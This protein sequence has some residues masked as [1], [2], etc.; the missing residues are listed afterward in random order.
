MSERLLVLAP[1]PDDEVLGCTALMSQTLADGGVVHVVVVTDGALGGPVQA[2]AQELQAGLA[3][4]G[5]PAAECWAYPDDALPQ[6]G[7]VLDRYRALVR[8]WRPTHLA[9][10]APGEAH[11]D[12]RRLTRGVIEALT[13]HWS[14][15]LVFYETTTPQVQVNQLVPLDLDRKLQALA[16]HASQMAQFDYQGYA[17]GLALLR[18]ASVGLPAAEGHLCFEWDGSAQNFFEHRPLVSVVLR[19]HDDSLLS[20]AL[21]SLRLQTYDHLEALVI[22]HGDAALPALPPDLAGQVVRGPGPHG[23]NLN[24]GLDLAR[25][26]FVAFLDHDDVWKPDHLAIL[27]AELNADTGLDLAYGDY[28]RVVCRH[29]A[30]GVQVMQRELV[31]TRD[32]RPARLMVGNHIPLHSFVCRTRLARR[33]RFD[34]ALGAYEDWDFLLRLELDDARLRRVPAVV[35]EYRIYPQPG[36]LHDLPTQHARKGYLRWRHEVVSRLLPRLTPDRLEVL[37]ALTEDL[38]SERDVLLQRVRDADA[39]RRQAEQTL[40]QQTRT[41]TE[42]HHW[43]DRLAPDTL[44]HSPLSRLVGRA[45][46]DGPVIAVLMPV[47]DP[48]PAFLIEVVESVRQQTYPNWQLCL[49]DDACRRPEVRA[50]LQG[51]GRLDPRIR[52]IRN[53]ERGGIVQATT[54]ALQLTQA[55]WLAF[56]DHDDR[57]DPDALLEIAAAVRADPALQALYTDSRMI[58]R[59]GVV[60]HTYAKPP[61]C[62]ETLLHLNYINH[63]SVVKREVF[64]AVGGLRPGLDGSQDWDLWLRLAQRPDL[65]VGHVAQP[66][67]DWRAAETSVAYSMATKPYI[68][69]AACR[70]TREHLQARGLQ[71]VDSRVAEGAGGLRHHWAANLLPMTAII[72]THHNPEDL[73]ALVA[74]L[75]ASTYPGLRVHVVANRVSPDDAATQTLLAEVAAWSH[76]QV[77]VD[78]R[79]FNWSALNNAEARHCTTPWLL[80]LNDDVAWDAPDTLERL[81]RYLTLDLQIGA[82]GMALHY[83]KDQGGG[84]QHDGVAT[85][86]VWVARNIQDE[87]D[88]KGLG[89]P[90]NVSAVTGACLLT[91]RAVFERCGGFDERLAV[92]YNDVDYGLHLRRLGYRV[93]QASDVQGRHHESKTRGTPD[94]PAKLAQLA[95]EGQ[96]MRDKWGDLLRETHRLDYQSRFVGSRIVHMPQEG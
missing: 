96:W 92:S 15:T 36:E 70:A 56:V 29:D 38:E 85:D 23:A 28:E 47:C 39:A 3:V 61:W 17:R 57:L 72:L 43:A 31:Q 37:R 30:Q 66:L 60:L 6:S 80:F 68:V 62:P 59:N 76:G 24:L 89:I 41:L 4:L 21:D 53:P 86:P 65:K 1:H 19:A 45:M 44:V 71:S 16:C 94:T 9:L 83:G 54:L 63:L 12:H 26:E 91:P 40:A 2:R 64:E 78:D 69:D 81:A 42:L 84:L 27:V 50:I 18:G 8:R 13:G 51:L 10:P 73:A 55:D 35:C 93:V 14:G 33:L 32:H 49:A 5:L 20:V 87:L 74:S 77:R 48:D 22:W 79:P 90:R 52:V 82:V 11:P 46:A 25:G 88:G 67:Y 7:E 95:Q 58:D 34:E 75:R